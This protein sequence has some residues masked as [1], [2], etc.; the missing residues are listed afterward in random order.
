MTGN[1]IPHKLNMPIDQ[2]KASII[3]SVYKDIEALR[4]ILAALERQTEKS[5]EIIVTEDG[6]FSD[7]SDYLTHQQETRKKIIHLTQKDDGFH[8]TRAVNRGIAAA[9]APYVMFLDGDCCPQPTFVERH[10]A[11]A[12]HK[13]ICTGRKVNLGPR[14]SA[15]IRKLP[16]LTRL[17]DNKL[18]FLLLAIPLHIDRLRNFETGIG[19]RLMHHFARHR[20]LG[21]MGCNWSGFKEDLLSINGYNEDLPGIGGEDDDL[22]WR[23]NGLGIHTKNTKFLTPV[24]HLYHDSRRMDYEINIAIMNE[25]KAKKQYRCLNGIVKPDQKPDQ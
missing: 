12:D 7:L 1:N 16:V 8:K 11:N 22:E 3:I 5:F 20:H 2:L 4:C 6:E 18:I 25:N 21:I 13:R 17:L 10:L 23:F 15:I 9:H 24:Y 14:A 19:G